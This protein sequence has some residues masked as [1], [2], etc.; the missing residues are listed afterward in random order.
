MRPRSGIVKFAPNSLRAAAAEDS[1]RA[2]QVGI[3]ADLHPILKR[4]RFWPS[5]PA[6]DNR[7]RHCRNFGGCVAR[8]DL[9]NFPAQKTGPEA[10]A[11]QQQAVVAEKASSP[12]TSPP[13]RGRIVSRYPPNNQST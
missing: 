12:V 13:K 4:E 1:A 10:H 8:I 11:D 6:R 2:A 9:V 3:W 5:S 7:P